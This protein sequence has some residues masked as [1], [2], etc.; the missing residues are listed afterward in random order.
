MT[1][2]SGRWKYVK[3]AFD[4]SNHAIIQTRFAGPTVFLRRTKNNSTGLTTK[5]YPGQCLR[6]PL[7]EHL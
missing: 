6:P 3:L 1:I 7:Y 5:P 4:F 2:L